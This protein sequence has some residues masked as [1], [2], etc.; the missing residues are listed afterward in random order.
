MTRP[1][2]GI[3]GNRFLVNDTY[4][5]TGT[6][7]LN[8]RAIVDA[9]DAVPLII[10]TDENVYDL[11]ELMRICDGFL[12][13]GAR[14]NVHPS[15]YGHDV[16]EAHGDF[17]QARDA[18]SLSLIRALTQRGQPYL[19]VCRGFQ[20]V[21][22]AFGCTLHPEIRDIDGRDNH[23]MPPD[24]TLEEKFALRHE[25][26]LTPNGP[27][28][29]VFGA[30]RVMTNSLHGQGIL[31]SSDQIVIDGYAPDGTP[32]AIYVKGAKGFTLSVQWHPEWRAAEDTVSKPLFAAFGKAVADWHMSKLR[33][34]ALA[35]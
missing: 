31:D 22:V 17:D 8:V 20:E 19:G 6:G 10:S 15:E 27:F 5:V 24:G 25:V 28:A 2:V 29:R 14:A 32:E 13:T 33:Q 9:T 34:P 11:E 35:V 18:L 4:Q 23:R 1:I 26:T 7:S 3:I 21:A 30:D 16:T 12:F